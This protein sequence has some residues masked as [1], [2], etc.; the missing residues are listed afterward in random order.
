MTE[1]N[2]TPQQLT[3]QVN[4]HHLQASAPETFQPYPYGTDASA[5][6]APARPASP[7]NVPGIV[8]LVL[9]GVAI[10]FALFPVIRL[11]NTV[12]MLV[13]FVLGIIALFR[14]GETKWEAIVAIVISV[15]WLTFHAVM[16]ILVRIMFQM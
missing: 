6:W 10:S 16:F 7:R 8:A 2:Y 11:L 14:A 9:V 12:L 3:Q 4:L 13:A 1:E 5:Q 15:I